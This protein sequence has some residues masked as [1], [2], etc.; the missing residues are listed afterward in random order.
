MPHPQCSIAV[1]IGDM[2]VLPPLSAGLITTFFIW[3]SSL[4]AC[5]CL[6]LRLSDIAYGGIFCNSSVTRRTKRSTL[7]HKFSGGNF[8]DL[9]FRLISLLPGPHWTYPWFE[10]DSCLKSVTPFLLLLIVVLFEYGWYH[11][12]N[13]LKNSLFKCSFNSIFL[14]IF[15]SVKHV[16]K[17]FHI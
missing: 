16:L 9:G 10:H 7:G 3:L 5:L 17:C 14:C 8:L 11:Y 13:I 6:E 4:N 2:T 12:I 1:S 15:Y